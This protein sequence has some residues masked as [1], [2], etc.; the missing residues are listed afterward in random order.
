MP[1]TIQ[2]WGYSRGGAIEDILYN[3]A[4]PERQPLRPV[5]VL[6]R[7]S[8]ELELQLARQWLE[9]QQPV[10]CTRKSF[11]FSPVFTGEFCFKICPF[12]P[13]AIL[14]ISS[15]LADSRIYFFESNDFVSHKTRNKIFTVSIFLMAMQIYDRFSSLGKKLAIEMASIISTRSVS[16]L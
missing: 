14:P 15:S 7:R 10:G 11:H 12:Q 13:P 1:D 5:S 3:S 9:C 4:Q 2:P 6:E 8:V 16:I